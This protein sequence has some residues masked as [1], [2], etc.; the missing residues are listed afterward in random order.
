[1]G[2]LNAAN[3][4]NTDLGFSGSYTGATGTPTFVLD[5]TGAV[6]GLQSGTTGALFFDQDGNGLVD[7]R[8]ASF[9]GSSSLVGFTASDIILF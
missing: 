5:A 1:V 3:F 2:V 4:V 9:G 8:V 6:S 7:F